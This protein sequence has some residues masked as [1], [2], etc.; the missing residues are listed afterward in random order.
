MLKLARGK[1]S[2]SSKA[3]LL[4]IKAYI[5][6]T[7][8]PDAFIR[9]AGTYARS[10]YNIPDWIAYLRQ[11]DF[12]VG[13]RIHGIVLA[14]QAEVPALCIA[15][16]SRTLELCE[17]MRIP[18]MASTDMATGITQEDI[19]QLFNFYPEEFDLNRAKLARSYVRFLRNNGLEPASFLAELYV[20]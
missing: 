3:V 17:T 4:K 1:A 19:P 8:S 15:H 16:D 6:P 5:C 14:L 18:Y 11:F 20:K 13:T 9:W 10:F 12:V 2:S 7:L